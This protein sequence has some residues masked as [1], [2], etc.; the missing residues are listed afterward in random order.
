[1]SFSGTA[2]SDFLKYLKVQDKDK[3][4]L[5]NFAATDFLALRDSL[6]Q[7]IKT[8]YPLDYNYFVESDLGMMLVELIA[9]M[10]HVSSYK[11]DYLANENFLRTARSRDSIRKLMQLIGIRMKGPIAATASARVS[12]QADPGWGPNSKLVIDGPSRVLTVKSSEDGGGV[13]YTMYKVSQNGDIDLSNK[14]ASIVID[15]S[16]KTTP[17]LL[18]NIVLQEGALVVQTGFFSDTEALKTVALNNS[19]VIEGSMQAFVTSEGTSNGKYRLVDN[20]F[21]ASGSDDK[22]FQFVPDENYGGFVVFGDNNLGKTPGIGDQYTVIYRVGGGS[23]G[24]VARESINAKAKAK[25]YTSSMSDVPTEIDLVVENSSKAT[26]GADAETID[27]VKRYG[28][29]VFRAQDRLVTLG[30]YKAF[31]NSYITAY[32]SVGKA[33]AATRRAYSSANIIDLYVLEKA[34]S[35]QMRKATPE[36]KRQLAEAILDKKM[37]TDEVVIVDGLIRTLD[38]SITLK[39]ER[40]YSTIENSIKNKANEKILEF[41]NVD[42]TDFGVEFNPQALLYKL[43]EV[44]EVR[45]ATIDNIPEAIPMAINEICQLNNYTI[46]ITYV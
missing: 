15:S 23:R 8:V 12:M 20:I 24:N 13:T 44:P 36:F 34:D 16:E 43:F 33:T 5:I 27:H 10:G 9:Y 21:Y 2:Q 37:I 41:F 46:N 26:G 4:N 18:Q 30:D 32:G 6:I 14:D 45:Y 17:T 19:P 39:L 35:I 42:N 29:L 7:Y 40:R 3:E 22:V 31:A 38:V 11:A 28:P 25:F 1:M